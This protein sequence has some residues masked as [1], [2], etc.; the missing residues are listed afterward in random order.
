MDNTLGAILIA[1]F[2]AI[3]GGLLA[4][5]ASAVHIG[6]EC[7]RLGGFWVRTTVYECKAS[8]GEGQ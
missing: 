7:D 3:I 6:K 2:S 1:V 5:E 4:W 8:K